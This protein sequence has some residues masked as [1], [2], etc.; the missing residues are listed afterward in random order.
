VLRTQNRWEEAIF[1][2]EAALALN[3]N[4]ASALHDL[5]V[6]KLF[7]EVIDEV[8]P[9]AGCGKSPA[10][11]SLAPLVRMRRRSIRYSLFRFAAQPT[12]SAAC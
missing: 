12:F 10:S 3:R 7:T 8:I 11:A 2:Y 1:E 6:C 5:A 4:S 9:L